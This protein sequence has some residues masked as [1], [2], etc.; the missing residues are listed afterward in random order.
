M[1]WGTPRPSELLTWGRVRELLRVLAEQDDFNVAAT[2][3]AGSCRAREERLREERMQLAMILMRASISF[4]KDKGGDRSRN[5]GQ[6]F[7]SQSLTSPTGESELALASPVV[8]VGEGDSFQ[9]QRVGT[10]YETVTSAGADCGGFCGFSKGTDFSELSEINRTE[11]KAA[12]FLA[13]LT[14]TRKHTF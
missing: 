14:G 7:K 8:H 11:F 13:K 4:P 2:H 12:I 3:P 9:G 5:R 1:E 10:Q 6:V